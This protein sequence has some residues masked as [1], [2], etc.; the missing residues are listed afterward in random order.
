[1][2]QIFQQQYFNNSI[3]SYIYVVLAIFIAICL[4]RFVSKY[5]ARVLYNLMAKKGGYFQKQAFVQLIIA[6]LESFLVIFISIIALDTLTYPT[7]LNFTIYKIH[8]F[9][10]VEAIANTALIYTFIW[11]CLRVVDFAAVVLNEKAKQTPDQTDD[12]LI[13]F[14]KDFFKAILTII[15]VLLVLRFAF[16]KNINNLITGLSIAGAAIALATKESLE[17]LIASFIIFFDKPFSVNDLV[18]VST[19]SG[20]VEKIGL[21]STRIRTDDKTYVT[22]PN[23]QMV[24]SIVDNISLR[25]QRR[26]YLIFELHI[27]T[28]PQKITQFIQQTQ[29]YLQT[30]CFFD[31]YNVVLKDTGKNAHIIEAEYFSSIQ[32]PYN[33]FLI[34]KQHVQL[35]MLQLLQN[36]QIQL[37]AT[38]LKNP[39]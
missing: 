38:E 26:G 15:G 14:F 27:S 31:T 30:I 25:S 5:L 24:D 18:K 16:N 22:V 1:M 7:W 3:K 20:T 9:K 37:A 29:L 12:Q 17:N 2:F 35:H 28:S 11:L 34:Q 4:K 39:N 13:I 36:N 8:F 23:K 6:P 32:Q 21:R 33:E 10:I 19:V